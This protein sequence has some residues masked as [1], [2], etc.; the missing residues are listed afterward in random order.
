MT[1]HR[2]GAAHHMHHFHTQSSK[3]D[4]PVSL[5]VC[6]FVSALYVCLLQLHNYELLKDCC[7]PLIEEIRQCIGAGKVKASQICSYKKVLELTTTKYVSCCISCSLSVRIK[8][9]MMRETSWPRD[10][11][12]HCGYTGQRMQYLEYPSPL[13]CCTGYAV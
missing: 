10:F 2:R 3:C 1:L 5:Y 12:L 8:L 11:A 7:A 4:T 13:S 6:L 9:H